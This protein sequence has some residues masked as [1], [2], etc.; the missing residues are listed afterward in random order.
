MGRSA[1]TRS[2]AKS[3]TKK[4][5]VTPTTVSRGGRLKK[6]GKGIGSWLKGAAKNTGKFLYKHGST[7]ATTAAAAAALAAAGYGTYKGAKAVEHGY[8]KGKEAVDYAS[9]KVGDAV[10]YAGQ[11]IVNTDRAAQE[12]IRQAGKSAHYISQ[13]AAE[14]YFPESHSSFPFDETLAITEANN[15]KRREASKQRMMQPGYERTFVN[16][17]VQ[18]DVDALSRQRAGVHYQDEFFDAREWGGSI[19]DGARHLRTAHDM[20]TFFDA[21]VARHGIQALDDR[22]RQFEIGAPANPSHR[23]RMFGRV[24]RRVLAHSVR[25]GNNQDLPREDRGGKIKGGSGKAERM[26]KRDEHERRLMEDYEDTRDTLRHP[27]IT[28]AQT[29]HYR[30]RLRFLQE[31]MRGLST[32]RDMDDR[33]G[34]PLPTLTKDGATA[35]FGVKEGKGLKHCPASFGGRMTVKRLEH[36]K[37]CQKCSTGKGAH[38]LKALG[39][40]KLH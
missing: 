15:Q 22:I 23:R 13:G 5:G 32:H 33:E 18:A 16:P 28:P 9:K 30:G 37:H 27:N 35:K 21:Y 8:K 38:V 1:T 40:I 31:M 11:T 10:D 19:N 25:T 4:R 14:H 12:A 29:E 3:S 34:R 26:E 39:S 20:Q 17:S 2:K 6:K 36:L 24:M 7:I